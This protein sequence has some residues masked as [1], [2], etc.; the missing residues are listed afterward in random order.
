MDGLFPRGKKRRYTARLQVP[1]QFLNIVGRKEIWQATGTADYEEAVE[2]RVKWKR[3]MLAQ[4]NAALAGQQ[5]LTAKSRYQIAAELAASRGQE[6]RTADDVSEMAIEK[7]LGRVELLK[8][9]KDSPDSDAAQAILGGVAI[10]KMTLMEVAESMPE[11]YPEDWKTKTERGKKVWERRWLRPAEKFVAL[12]GNDPEFTQIER[13][14]AVAFRDA[15]K[16]RVID[17]DYKA[18]SAMTEL[19]NLNG[20]WKRHHVALGV[21]IEDVPPSPWRNLSTPLSKLAEGDGQ[22]LEIPMQNL[23]KIIAPGALSAMNEEARDLIYVLIETGARQAEVT[24]LPPGSIHL[25][26][27]IPHIE[28]KK[29]TGEFSRTIKN[30]AS[31]RRIPLVGIG[32]EALRRHPQGFPRY[33]GKGTFSA[34][35]NAFLH[36]NKLLPEDI[37]IGGTRHSYESRMVD[38][39]FSNEDRA[40]MMG[41]SIKRVRG[42]EVYGNP[43][44]LAEKLSIAEAIK[45]IP[46]LT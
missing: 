33:R 6:Y 22:K 31:K 14:Q 45:L 9:N 11:R 30:K 15:L 36:E 42:R 23:M 5:P 26:H 38:A 4:W 7:L 3:Q 19:Q 37:T 10:P 41:H 39:H 21:D 46:A 44:S 20:L 18:E 12:I 8:A 17:E 1:T 24:D 43:L 40:A 35:A 32:L 27:E 16:D 13:K 2:F 34:A 25:E 28:I 29:E